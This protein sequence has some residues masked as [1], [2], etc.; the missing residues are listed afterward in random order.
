MKLALNGKG[1]L[2]NS[3]FENKSDPAT[4]ESYGKSVGSRWE[5]NSHHPVCRTDAFPVKLQELF[6]YCNKLL[7]TRNLERKEEFISEVL[8]LFFHS[9][10]EIMQFLN[11]CLYLPRKAWDHPSRNFHVSYSDF[12]FRPREKSHSQ[13]N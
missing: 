7:E 9:Q 1:I 6:Y 5:L 11:S 3:L 8:D 12:H 4:L 10:W 13:L 2:W